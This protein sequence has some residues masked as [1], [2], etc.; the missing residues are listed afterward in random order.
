M[1]TK[2]RILL[3][4]GTLMLAVVLVILTVIVFVFAHASSNN[5]M[6]T[7]QEHLEQN[8]DGIRELILLAASPGR[9]S[10]SNN[11]PGRN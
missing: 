11:S 4:A 9:R 8:E 3:A 10:S 7:A 6:I 5:P 1:N 2:E